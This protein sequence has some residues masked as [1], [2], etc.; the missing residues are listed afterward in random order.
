[1]PI[2]DIINQCGTMSC[3]I[4]LNDL[5]I[6]SEL[7]IQTNN[8]V[9]TSIKFGLRSIS[10]IM[11]N[12]RII[13]PISKESNKL[14][15]ILLK[16]KLPSFY[17]PSILSMWDI[18]I[19]KIINYNDCLIDI[20]TQIQSLH[21]DLYDILN[22][23]NWINKFISLISKRS[24]NDKLKKNKE[25]LYGPRETEEI[26]KIDNP[27]YLSY[28]QLF[29]DNIVP[30]S[31]HLIMKKWN[32][33]YSSLFVQSPNIF[34]SNT[35]N[36]KT[37]LDLSISSD[38]FFL[39][40]RDIHNSYDVF[41][42]GDLNGKMSLSL[43]ESK[44]MYLK[45]LISK[46]YLYTNKSIAQFIS[47][48]LSKRKSV[49]KKTEKSN[50]KPFIIKLDLLCDAIEYRIDYSENNEN[51]MNNNGD[52]NGN[53]G[54]NCNV[55]ESSNISYIKTSLLQLNKIKFDM[56]K[57]NNLT[58]FLSLDNMYHSINNNTT[59]ILTPQSNFLNFLYKQNDKNKSMILSFNDLCIYLNYGF[60]NAL[61]DMIKTEPERVLLYSP[62]KKKENYN[63]VV[64]FKFY[65]RMKK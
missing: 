41:K 47:T 45:L 31:L 64:Y 25:K 62:I 57:D 51:V 37:L 54:D 28:K 13:Y 12:N 44:E 22:I 59:T 46:I 58:L 17:F 39:S 29:L 55:N 1:M 40:F 4:T 60:I 35:S 9:L 11:M 38:G 48:E 30:I 8:Y 49:N 27:Q 32:I 15:D 16:L 6:F 10:L 43:K 50:S 52:E 19:P 23:V 3:N 65:F 61:I 53:N 21:I 42:G 2:N 24:R 56:I 14:I 7:F 63:F 5:E 36:K 33:D 18:S 26:I 20:N 34:I